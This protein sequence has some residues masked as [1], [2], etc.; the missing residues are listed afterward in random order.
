MATSDAGGSGVRWWRRSRDLAQ[1]DAR[2]AQ[3]DAARAMTHLESLE[4]DLTELSEIDAA[5]AAARAGAD[6]VGFTTPLSQDWD[7]LSVETGIVALQFYELDAAYDPRVDH[8]EAEA[9]RFAD[10]FTATAAR[11]RALFPDVERFRAVHAAGLEAAAAWRDET[12]D[13]VERADAA[14][15]EARQVLAE[16]SGLGLRDDDATSSLARAGTGIAAARAAS[17]ERRWV[18]AHTAAADAVEAA[19]SAL[20]L[21]RDLP[22]RAERVRTGLLSVR[23]RRDAIRT[24][25]A[26]L[27]EVM[28]NLRRRYTFDAWRDVDGAPQRVEAALK[29]IED[30]LVELDR[31]VAQAPLDVPAATDLLTSVR[32]AINDA[33]QDL[34]N[35]TDRLQRLDSLAD[36]PGALLERLRRRLVDARRFLDGLPG[37]PT[38]YGPTL[39]ALARRTEGLVDQVSAT[40]PNWG[41]IVAEADSIEAGLDAMIR[42][43]RGH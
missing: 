14:R 41:A 36:D 32:T 38:R 33:N 12:P 17:E 35:A 8:E 20:R 22:D 25:H 30:G 19:E 31:L 21:A 7:R 40:R 15:T 42:T 26:R 2:A 39:D 37:D 10:G 24:Q 18:D 9:R 28:S 27:P 3:A 23:T 11:L 6:R 13:L 29:V 16:A 5:A 4:V 34:R 1:Q 43:A